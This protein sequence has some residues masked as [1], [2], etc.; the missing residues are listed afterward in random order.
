MI[1][2]SMVFQFRELLR[3]KLK[4]ESRRV[5]F[6]VP[7]YKIRGGA[8]VVNVRGNRKPEV[9]LALIERG[10]ANC[11]RPLTSDKRRAEPLGS[12]RT[13]LVGFWDCRQEAFPARSGVAL[14]LRPTSEAL[15]LFLRVNRPSTRQ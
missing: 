6:F 13:L 8:G 15:R 14:R 7:G 5:Q 11:N 10:K 2:R 3:V 4:I 9:R 12:W 1:S